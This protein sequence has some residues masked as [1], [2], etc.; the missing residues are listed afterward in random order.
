MDTILEMLFTSLGV[1]MITVT[2]VVIVGLCVVIWC[3]R[4]ID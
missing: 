4:R 3:T 2:V 1:V